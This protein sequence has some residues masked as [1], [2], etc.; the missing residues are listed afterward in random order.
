M[1]TGPAHQAARSGGAGAAVTPF[2][3]ATPEECGDSARLLA[4]LRGHIARLE[5]GHS[6]FERQKS[7]AAPWLTGLPELDRHLPAQGLRRAGLHD[8]SPRAYGDQPAAMGFALALALRRLNDMG[9]RRPL[10]WCRLA[11]HE[12]EHGRLYGHGL[13]R[14][15]LPRHRFVTITLRKPASLLWT[16]EEALKSGA[17]A[18][19]LGDAEAAHADLTA[20]RRLSLAAAAGKCAA[21]LTFARPDCAATASHTRWTAAAVPSLSPAHDAGAPGAPCWSVELTRARG[22]RPGAWTLEWHHAQ[23]R[24]SLVPGFSRRAIHPGTDQDGPEAARQEPAL[25]AG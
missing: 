25:R 12:R 13:E 7:R 9:E 2:R 22:G 14:L 20:T 5:Q 24:F 8:V 17:V 11:A 1:R 6:Q 21:I 18:A 4:T 10:L 16:M 3:P 15:G 23:S 19:V